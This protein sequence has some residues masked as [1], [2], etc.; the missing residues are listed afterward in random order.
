MRLNAPKGQTVKFC[1]VNG[2]PHELEEASSVLSSDKVY[3]V[4]YVNVYSS[5]SEVILQEFPDKIFN[6]VMFEEVGDKLPEVDT[7]EGLY[8]QQY[9]LRKVKNA[10]IA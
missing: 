2:Y 6:T 4:L 9:M 5:S 10:G 7:V 3:H 1:G 8:K